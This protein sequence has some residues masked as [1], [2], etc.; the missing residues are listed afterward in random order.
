MI[1]LSSWAWRTPAVHSLH[2]TSP[3]KHHDAAHLLSQGLPF[4]SQVSHLAVQT[5]RDTGA[6][7][8]IVQTLI[9]SLTAATNIQSLRTYKDGDWLPTNSLIKGGNRA[10]PS[11]GQ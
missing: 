4:Q 2:L 1:S 9:L 8:R 6:A 11:S 7:V 3:V 10:L 5:A